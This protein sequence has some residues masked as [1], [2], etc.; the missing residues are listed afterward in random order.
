MDRRTKLKY[1]AGAIA[2]LALAAFVGAAVALAAAGLLDGDGERLARSEEPRFVA[3][4]LERRFEDPTPFGFGGP[5][6]FEGWLDLEEAADYLGLDRDELLDELADGNSLADI[7]RDEG[8]SVDRLVQALVE[9]A[10]ERIDDAAASGRLSGEQADELKED[11]EERIQD[12]V[13]DEFPL[14]K[15]FWFERDFERPRGFNG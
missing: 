2:A 10:E 15:R 9:A 8:K 7:A 13:D 4:E 1:A 5:L 12:R 11:L 14:P 6:R 3:P